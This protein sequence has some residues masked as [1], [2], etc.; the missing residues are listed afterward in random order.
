MVAEF[1]QAGL[2]DCEISRRTG[3]PRCTVRDWRHG[4]RKSRP[5]S[6]TGCPVC[7]FPSHDPQTLPHEAYSYLLGLHLGDGHIVH[8]T[9]GVYRLRVFLDLRYPG[10]IAACAAATEAVIGKPAGMAAQP[11]CVAVNSY[12]K[13]WPCLFPQ[14]G[15]GRKHE[16]SIFL[17]DWQ[18]A[19]VDEHPEALLRGLI[20]SDGC[21]HMRRVAASG[22]RYAYPRYQFC[23]ASDDIRRIFLRRV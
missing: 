5:A 9:R 11:R 17:A 7:G 22:K 15:R 4:K 2:N 21:R 18:Q 20:H 6:P 1:L 13:Q 10:I 8:T 14:H 3:I 19:I 12:S 23:N 16:R